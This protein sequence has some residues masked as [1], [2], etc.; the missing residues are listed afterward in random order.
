MSKFKRA[1]QWLTF[2]HQWLLFNAKQQDVFD[3]GKQIAIHLNGRN[4]PI[5]S[6][7]N[8]FIGDHVIV[9]NSKDVSMPLKEWRTRM[10]YHHS[11]YAKGTTWASA[12]ELHLRDP[13]IVL[14]KAIYKELRSSHERRTLM[15]RCHIFPDDNVPEELMANVCD[16]IRQVQP[17]IKSINEYTDEEIRNFP[18]LVKQSDEFTTETVYEGKEIVAME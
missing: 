9:I 8:Q 1:Q 11:L 3:A 10:Y 12:Y 17:M 18:K 5:Y 13:T 7:Q 2:T 6:R 16:E 4:K 15:A 14:Y